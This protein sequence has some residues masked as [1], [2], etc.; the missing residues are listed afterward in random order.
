[1]IMGKKLDKLKA[2]LVKA[3]GASKTMQKVGD[4]ARKM[5]EG[6]FEVPKLDLD[7]LFGKKKKRK[8]S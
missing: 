8:I 7:D 4:R 5:Q 1:M 2:V 3:Q 6:M